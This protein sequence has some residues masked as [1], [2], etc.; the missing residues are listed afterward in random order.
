M[1]TN[2][3]TI[4]IVLLALIVLWAV[5]HYIATERHLYQPDEPIRLQTADQSVQN[6]TLILPKRGGEYDF[7]KP[8]VYR[9]IFSLFQTINLPAYFISYISALLTLLLVYYWFTTWGVSRFYALVGLGLLSATPLFFVSAQMVKIDALFVLFITITMY[10]LSKIIIQPDHIVFYIGVAAGITVSVLT[11]GVLGA[12][13]PILVALYFYKQINHRYSLWA[14]LSSVS[15]IISYLGLIQWLYAVPIVNRY[16]FKHT[17]SRFFIPGGPG[18]V[19]SIFDSLAAL[20][21]LFMPLV[22][23]LV[24]ATF[25]TRKSQ[26]MMAWAT[27]AILLPLVSATTMPVYFLPAC[28]PL[29][30]LGVTAFEKNKADL[31]APFIVYE[32]LCLAAILGFY[33]TPGARF[34]SGPWFVLLPFG[35]TGFIVETVIIVWGISWAAGLF[36]W[37]YKNY[38]AVL[39]TLITQQ[40]VLLLIGAVLAVPFLN[41]YYSMETVANWALTTCPARTLQY[42]GTRRQAKKRGVYALEYYLGPSIQWGKTN[43]NRPY[44]TIKKV[45]RTYLKQ[46]NRCSEKDTFCYPEPTAA[47]VFIRNNYI[48]KI[49]K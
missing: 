19:Q 46:T 15:L 4:C 34:L 42:D 49:N 23:F 17:I 3:A 35:S 21:F 44:C 47:P 36:F 20:P 1:E 18:P 33:V 48:L 37:T 41:T 39:G 28:V 9:I 22:P 11:K 29:V 8:P 40:V 45:T 14:L 26:F 7:H 27:G 31:L 2:K 5:P 10:F 6:N 13:L 24:L 16:I 12:A 32:L 38:P 43:R 25:R 30:Y